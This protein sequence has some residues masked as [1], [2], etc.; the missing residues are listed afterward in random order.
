MIAFLFFDVVPRP[1]E[2]DYPRLR[3]VRLSKPEGTP[4]R[5]DAALDKYESAAGRGL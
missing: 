4:K 2:R 1:V 5:H 3:T